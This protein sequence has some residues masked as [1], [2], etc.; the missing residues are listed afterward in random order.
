MA[1]IISVVRST[2]DDRDQARLAFF[3][4][5]QRAIDVEI[6][7]F[8]GIPQFVSQDEPKLPWAL[9]ELIGMQ[10]DH[11]NRLARRA[12]ELRLVAQAEDGLWLIENQVADG[13]RLLIP[14]TMSTESQ[15]VRAF[16]ESTA[17]TDSRIIQGHSGHKED[18][19]Q[20]AVINRG[21]RRMRRSVCRA[22][23]LSCQ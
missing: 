8:M 16:A 11:W 4:L 2:F 19:F 23:S 22:A 20:E 3:S 9:T 5:F 14:L 18:C 17:L 10:Q 13:L 1:E 7:I 12:H 15:R 21:R 6:L